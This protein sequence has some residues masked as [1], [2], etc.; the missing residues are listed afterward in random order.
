[1]ALVLLG[2]SVVECLTVVGYEVL[3]MS[4]R[5]FLII[6]DSQELPVQV[7][8]HGLHQAEHLTELLRF[9]QEG[10]NQLT[11]RMSRLYLTTVL[12]AM[13]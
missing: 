8:L 5:G 12:E 9:Y 7:V 6:M 13:G 4:N 10:L 1:M 3:H 2:T 11:K